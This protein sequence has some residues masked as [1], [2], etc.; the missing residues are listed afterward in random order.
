MKVTFFNFGAELASS[1][2]RAIIPQLELGKMGVEQG[3]DVLIYGKHFLSFNELSGY[4]K[5]IFDVCDDHL[6]H[7][8]LGRYYTEHLMEADAITCNSEVMK[9]RI[10]EVT[11][12]RAT[13]VSEPYEHEEMEPGIGKSLLW[14]GHKSN[15]KDLARIVPDLPYSLVVLSNNEV[16]VQW[17]PQAFDHEIKKPCIVIIPT[18]KKQA[19]SENRMVEAIRCG[20]YVCAEHLPS[21]EAFGEFFPLGD[22]PKHI[23]LALDNPLQ[24]IERI[25]EAQAYIRDKYSPRTIAEQWLEVI[26]GIS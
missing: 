10:Y 14:Y 1:R 11:G 12:R 15:L 25:K 3:N 21:Y 4:K 13:V 7:P 19:K 23:E 2:L 16:C 6:D 17:T 20:R 24:S 18:G 8:D 26:N 9:Q 5:Q 22:I